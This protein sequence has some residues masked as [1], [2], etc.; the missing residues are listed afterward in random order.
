M[1]EFF[2]DCV[3][4][5][6][7]QTLES[8][9]MATADPASHK[10]VM[11]QAVCLLANETNFPS[12]PHATRALQQIVHAVTGDADPYRQVKTQHLA[13]AGR[14][15]PEVRRLLLEKDDALYWA[16]KASA[17]GNALDAAVSPSAAIHSAQ[18]ELE[19]PFAVCDL[20]IL[21]TKLETAK[22]L[23]LIGDN[24]GETVLDGLLLEQCRHLRLT[25]AVRGAP[26]LNDATADD[27]VASGVSDYAEILPTGSSLPGVDL[28][29]CSDA[30]LAQ[31]YAADIVICKGQGNFETLW[32]CD[33]DL[34]FLFKV[35]CPVIA[36]AL[37][38]ELNTYI[39]RYQPRP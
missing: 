9:R 19:K 27:A 38:M 7:R 16:L 10:A 32:G 23:L 12:A 18:Q 26:I 35:K 25:Y 39:L 30:F 28:R 31:F 34:F 15:L 5:V 13:M 11:D 22:N 8:A 6:L 2:L 14:L 37:G 17:M 33:R 20:P 21:R 3:P 4:C 1:M 29:E 24:A 36:A